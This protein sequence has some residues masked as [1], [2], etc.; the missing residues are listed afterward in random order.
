[1]EFF[2]DFLDQLAV[3][4]KKGIAAAT[5]I[6]EEALPAQLLVAFKIT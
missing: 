4:L 1:M 2:I 5:P 3:L 6:A